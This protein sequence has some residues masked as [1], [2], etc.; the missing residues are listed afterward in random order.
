MAHVWYTYTFQ[1]WG[2]DH[3]ISKYLHNSYLGTWG[4][5]IWVPRYFLE[6]VLP[7]STN[8]LVHY[9]LYWPDPIKDSKKKC[10]WM[11][12]YFKWYIELYAG[13]RHFKLFT[14]YPYHHFEIGIY[15]EESKNCRYLHYLMNYIIPDLKVLQLHHIEVWV[16]Y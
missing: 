3:W 1:N 13:S 8:A 11:I 12:V 14:V 10:T 16:V 5:Y 7:D 6:G 15:L 2:S 9:L 4:V